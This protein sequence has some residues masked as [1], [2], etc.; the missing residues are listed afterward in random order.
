MNFSL[1]DDA[2]L[3]I[4][5]T[6][7]KRFEHLFCKI[8]QSCLIEKDFRKTKLNKRKETFRDVSKVKDTFSYFVI[9][10]HTRNSTFVIPLN[11]RFNRTFLLHVCLFLTDQG[12]QTLSLLVAD[13]P[14]KR[15][16][17]CWKIRSNKRGVF[18]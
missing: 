4:N 5:L 17:S 6:N 2:I 18:S 3:E 9:A 13:Q 11:K 10:Y 8:W 1:I 15:G 16:V 14:D 7:A 12:R